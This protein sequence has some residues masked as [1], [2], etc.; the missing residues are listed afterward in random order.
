MDS[1]VSPL[2]APE[3]P[4]THHRSP[5]TSQKAAAAPAPDPPSTAQSGFLSYLGRCQQKGAPQGCMV[6]SPDQ[7]S[8]A[9]ATT[10]GSP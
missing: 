1:L 9:G 8:R 6:D 2:E 7:F 5:E 10:S 3:L 4:L